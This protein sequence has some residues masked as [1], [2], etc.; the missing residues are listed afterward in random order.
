MI[1]NTLISSI[2][3]ISLENFIPSFSIMDLLIVSTSFPYIL[4]KEYNQ[5]LV[6]MTFFST[7]FYV[8]GSFINFLTMFTL[9]ADSLSLSIKYFMMNLE[10]LIIYN[11]INFYYFFFY[12]LLS[13]VIILLML[14]IIAYKIG[15]KNLKR[16]IF[17]FIAFILFLDLPDLLIHLFHFLIYFLI[18][19]S[20]TKIPSIIFRHFIN[21]QDYGTIILSHIY[22]L[23]ALVY[24]YPFLNKSEYQNILISICIMDSF[25]SIFGLLFQT[26]NKSIYGF[27]AGQIS[28]YLFEYMLKKTI[29]YKYHLLMGI[30]ECFPVVNDNIS[31]PFFG[32]LHYKVKEYLN[33]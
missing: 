6:F 33:T 17:H 10:K 13:L 20:Y 25:A 2:L 12:K 22:L 4:S 31:L 27:I 8:E 26:Y 24:S 11:R 32:V 30:V 7:I 29:D 28:S 14:Q 16:K 3:I 15:N 23:S 21:K 5:P 19:L 9:L 1:Y 18:I